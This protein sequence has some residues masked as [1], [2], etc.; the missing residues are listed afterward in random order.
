MR[1]TKKC[2]IPECNNEYEYTF[3]GVN[4]CSTHFSNKKFDIVQKKKCMYCDI[5]EESTYVC[6][7][8]KAIKNKKEYA[9]VRYLKTKIKEDFKYNSSKVLNGCSRKRPDIFFEF[10]MHVVIVDIDESQHRFYNEICECAR[11][12]EIVNG[13]GGKSVIFIRYNPDSITNNKRKIE[14]PQA[15]RL[16][17]LVKT[18]NE[19]INK[20]YDTLIIKLIQLFYNDNYENYQMIKEED[21]TKKVII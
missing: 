20:K 16:E 7:D 19:E 10:A 18:I 9:I 2:S 3:V 12:N 8:C 6:S 1:P 17:L 14:I 13:V 5:E 11:L 15:K 4:F 21:I